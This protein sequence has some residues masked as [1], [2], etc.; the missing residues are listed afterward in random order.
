MKFRNAVHAFSYSIPYR[1]NSYST[2]NIFTA[3]AYTVGKSTFFISWDKI[4]KSK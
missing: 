3:A 2:A 4:K 1:E